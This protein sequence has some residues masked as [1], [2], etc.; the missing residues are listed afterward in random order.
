VATFLLRVALPDRPGALGAVAS[1]IGAVRGDVIAVEIVERANGR[2]VD[3]FIVDL[4][5]ED[6]VPLL[7]S[8]VGEVDGASVEEIHPVATGERDARFEAYDNAGAIVAERTPHAVL[9]VL[10]LRARH[11]FDASWA[12][13]IGIEEPLVLAS[14]GRPPAVSWLASYVDDT[15]RQA[16]AHP[17][18]DIVWVDLA[19]WDLVL[20]LGRPGWRFSD[21]E[22]KRLDALAR[23]ADA[24]WVHLVEH[25]ARGSHPSRAG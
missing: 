17:A 15:R 10:A 3:E 8:E 20:M 25:E 12:A 11:E 21:A 13:V 2:A 4:P 16:R 22:R 19:A 9:S 5:S 18:D 6:L 7:L 14:D 24:R 1:R 23:L